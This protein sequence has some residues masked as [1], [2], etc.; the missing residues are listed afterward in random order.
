MNRKK[1]YLMVVAGM[2]Y[3]TGCQS[4]IEKD[5]IGS[6][7]TTA[8]AIVTEDDKLSQFTIDFVRNRIDLAEYQNQYEDEVNEIKGN[9]YDNIS[10]QNCEMMP[11][12]GVKTVGIY[13]LYSNGMGVDESI[14]IIK[15]WLKEIGCEDIELEKELRDASGQY[16]SSDA[17]YPY[18]YP[19]VY[20]HYPEFHSGRGFFINTNK[21]Y[22]QMGTDGIYSMSDGSITNFLNLDSLAAMD[23]LGV[24]EEDIV[25]KGSVSL[26][27]DTV[28]ELPDGE[29]SIADAAKI[30]K[31]YFEAGTPRQNPSGIS[32]DVPEV[33]VFT[34]NDKYGYAFKVRRV[35]KG[36]P[37]AYVST[38]TG[39]YYSSVYEFKEDVKTAYMID[40][41]KVAAFTGY[42]DAEQLEA[43]IEEQTEIMSLKDAAL[44]L[45]DFLAANVK[46]EVDKA[47]LVY[48]TCMD[49]TGNNIV[50]PCWQFEGGNTTNSQRMRVYVNVL[51]GDVYY[52]SYMGE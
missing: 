37:F 21:C 28:W 4:Q 9:S 7:S 41:N 11:L 20:D 48:C 27:G 49:E 1:L 19:A 35:Y 36:V 39:I 22:I 24:N 47:G 26:K 25:D 23:A 40:H 42:V 15:N 46:L 8:E 38:A 6:E 12:E 17:E 34:L 18:D 13:R 33:E 2:L 43:L 52:Y 32:I 3:L 16:D 29:M 10:V 30:V 51:S 44:L 31:D 50:Y 45:D 14:E 5:I